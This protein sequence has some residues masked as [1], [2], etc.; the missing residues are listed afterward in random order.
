MVAQVGATFHKIFIPPG[1]SVRA[2]QSAVAA[3]EGVK[4][5]P[6]LH[7]SVFNVFKRFLFGGETF[8]ANVYSVDKDAKSPGYISLKG[9]PGEIYSHAVL[10]G[11]ELILASGSYLASQDLKI[12]TKIRS[13]F[14]MEGIFGVANLVATAEEKAGR[15]WFFS[16]S[17]GMIPY[18]RTR[19]Q[20]PLTLDVPV[21]GYQSTVELTTQVGWWSLF[22]GEGLVYK[23]EG[24]GTIYASTGGGVP[25]DNLVGQIIKG[26]TP[27]T[28][29]IVNWAAI[30]ALT[31]FATQSPSVQNFK[32]VLE[33][34]WK[35]PSFEF[36]TLTSSSS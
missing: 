3:Y 13:L 10:P 14:S 34:F 27:S 33:D 29:M 23:A 28:F 1:C 17:D 15:V 32:M 21:I 11:G 20:P 24:E 22:A 18:A 36:L 31:Y 12:A 4:L 7:D 35:N 9:R 8:F 2:N 5:E 30:G 26:V 19:E 16:P 25:R 6:G